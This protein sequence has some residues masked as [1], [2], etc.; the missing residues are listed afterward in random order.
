MKVIKLPIIQALEY[1]RDNELKIIK[2]VYWKGKK[3]IVE[4]RK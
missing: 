3:P 1:I 4:V 2:P